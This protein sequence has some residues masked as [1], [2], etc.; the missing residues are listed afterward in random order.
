MIHLVAA[1][2]W[3][4]LITI[5]IRWRAGLPLRKIMW[6]C[7][8]RRSNECRPGKRP[9]TATPE[10]ENSIKPLDNRLYPFS[11]RLM[12]YDN[13]TTLNQKAAVSYQVQWHGFT[14]ISEQSADISTKNGEDNE[15]HENFAV[16]RDNRRIRTCSI[17]RA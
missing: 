13:L 6:V 10:T 12:R 8:T 1:S 16:R 15:I 3:P 17:R 5:R 11:E 9:C 4:S 14:F 2:S 7:L